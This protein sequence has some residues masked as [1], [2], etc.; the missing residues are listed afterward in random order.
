MLTFETRRL[1]MRRLVENDEELY[2]GLYTDA[3][4]MRHIGVPLSP[5]QAARSFRKALTWSIKQLADPL[6]FAMLEK[7]TQLAI[8]LCA[9]QPFEA[10]TRSAE[11][12]MMLKSETRARGYATEGLAALVTVAFSALPIDAV[13]VQYSPE[14]TAAE[15]LVIRVGFARCADT[16]IG[17]ARSAK[18]VWSVDRSSWCSRGT[19][20]NQGEDNVERDRIS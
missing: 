15:R 4:T 1:Q 17:N 6:L 13:W 16:E 3:D 12:G 20:N 19:T 11:I 2:C 14:H 18:C 5:E 9:I 7:S 8:G 10:T